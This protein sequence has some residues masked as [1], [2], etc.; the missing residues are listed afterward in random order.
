M[1]L[2]LH[3]A[4]WKDWS[5][6]CHTTHTLPH[7]LQFSW[8][9]SGVWTNLMSKYGHKVLCL[10]LDIGSVLYAERCSHSHTAF[11]QPVISLKFYLFPC[12]PPLYFYYH[13]SICLLKDPLAPRTYQ[14]TPLVDLELVLVGNQCRKRLK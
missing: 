2:L 8:L 14:D 5:V 4:V 9:W 11:P 1:L 3:M 7:N 12:A 13:C 6:W 10:L